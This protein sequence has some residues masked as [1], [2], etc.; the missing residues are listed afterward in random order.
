MGGGVRCGPSVKLELN[1]T[2]VFVPLKLVQSYGDVICLLPSQEINI[3]I[4][5]NVSKV[6]G[7]AAWSKNCKWCSSLPLGTVVSLSYES[8]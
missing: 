8:V 2:K 5:E 7:L 1:V 6:S 3:Q 4:Y